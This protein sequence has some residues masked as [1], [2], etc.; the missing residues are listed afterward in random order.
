MVSRLGP[1]NDDNMIFI[2]ANWSMTCWSTKEGLETALGLVTEGCIVMSDLMLIS[3]I[4]VLFE[5]LEMTCAEATNALAS[6]AGN[7]KAEDLLSP[8]HLMCVFK[9]LNVS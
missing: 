4:S 9:K 7:L 1:R 3:I 2:C 8:L 6:W 5:P